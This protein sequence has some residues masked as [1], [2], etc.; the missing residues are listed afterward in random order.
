MHIAEPGKSLGSPQTIALMRELT[1]TQNLG[2]T[3]RQDTESRYCLNDF[4]K[5]NFAPMTYTASRYFLAA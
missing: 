5:R 2:I 1:D 4:H 3:I